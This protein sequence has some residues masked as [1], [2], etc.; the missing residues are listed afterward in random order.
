[1]PIQENELKKFIN[2]IPDGILI[3]IDFCYYDFLDVNFDFKQIINNE[4]VICLFSF[5]KFHGLANL[6]LGYVIT[7]QVVINLFKLCQITQVPTFKEEIALIGLNDKNH[8]NKVKNYY[9]NEKAKIFN[10][11]KIHKIEY[12]DSYQNFIYIKFNK[13]ENLKNELKKYDIYYDCIADLEGYVVLVIY[14]P[15]FNKK[16]L[17]S[18]IKISINNYLQYNENI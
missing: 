17:D 10:I 1:M 13:H 18:I 5:S 12:I 14:S 4:H 3:I 9:K 16:I 15:E 6:Q 8:N 2:K 7:N 11:L